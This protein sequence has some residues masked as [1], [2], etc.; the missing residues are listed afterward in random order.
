MN[1]RFTMAAHILAM[2]AR[3][4]QTGHGPV[5]SEVMAES[6]Q[7][8]PV[9]VRRVLGDLSRAGLVESKRG[10]GG[11]VLLARGADTIT[12]RDVYEAV[13]EG[14]ELFGRHPSGP[15]EDCTIAPVVAEYLEDVFGRAEA[16]LK[17]SLSATTVA[18]MSHEL[19]ARMRKRGVKGC[20]G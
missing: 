20:P 9:V 3:H 17:Q 14:S 19:G 10:V 2:L 16:A 4:E 1:S 8:N 15:N 13:E 5:T 7:T 18:K 12:L 6:I 11:G